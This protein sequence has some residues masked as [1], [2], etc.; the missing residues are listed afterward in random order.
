MEPKSPAEGRPPYL[1]IEM[2]LVTTAAGAAVV[3]VST[4]QQRVN[5]GSW[6]LIPIT[7]TAFALAPAAFRRTPRERLGFRACRPGRLAAHVGAACL[8]SAVVLALLAVVTRKTGLSAPLAPRVQPG[9]WWSWTVYQLMYVAVSEELFFRG[10]LQSNLLGLLGADVPDPPAAPAV[11]AIVISSLVF[12][13]AHVVVLR[14]P[15]SAVVFFP[16]LLMG[17]LRWR[18]GSLLAPMLYHGLANVM[19]AA[20]GAWV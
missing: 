1:L 9:Q 19:Y 8:V 14:A 12:A 16:S 6:L 4:L 11:G 17:W 13:L 7:W 18:T 10:Y 15:Q 20:F 2:I 5:V 3:A